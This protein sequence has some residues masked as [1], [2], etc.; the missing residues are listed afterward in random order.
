MSVFFCAANRGINHTF[1]RSSAQSLRRGAV[2]EKV[3][4]NN[5]IPA[6]NVYF[7]ELWDSVRISLESNADKS[8][9]E[10]NICYLSTS[11]SAP[12]DRLG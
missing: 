8:T 6:K 2:L 12:A 3:S 10:S 4:I 7:T 5:E 9:L 1:Y 11:I